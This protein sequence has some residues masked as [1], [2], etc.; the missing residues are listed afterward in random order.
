MHV[1]TTD[2]RRLKAQR[3]FEKPLLVA[4]VLSIPT[5]ILQTT[6]VGSLWGTVGTVLNWAIWTAF[7][8]ELAVMLMI[9]PRRGRYLVAHPLDLTIVLLTPPFLTGAVQ[10]VRLLR[11]LRVSRLLRLEPLARAAFSVEGVKAAGSLALLTAI[12]GGGGF[13][14]EEGISFGNGLYWATT[15]MTTVGYGDITPKTTEGKAI[16]VIVMLV[17]IGTA[18]LVIGAVAQ[19]FLAY[20]V[21]HV[22]TTEDDLLTQVREISTR[23]VSLEQA[24]RERT[25]VTDGE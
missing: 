14:A 15:T 18:T 16:A 7:L 6:Q 17:G 10:S 1:Q 19:R 2:A 3:F 20:A 5:T 21:E 25:K 12:A 4:A 22:E 8:T 13:A 9:V 11:L 24:L 23:L